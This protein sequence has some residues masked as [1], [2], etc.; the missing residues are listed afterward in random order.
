MLLTVIDPLA[1]AVMFVLLFLVV[2]SVLSC[3]LILIIYLAN[4]EARA[5]GVTYGLMFTHVF[6]IGLFAL[7]YW[8]C[9]ELPFPD[10]FKEMILYV[11]PVLLVIA[12]IVAWKP[13]LPGTQKKQEA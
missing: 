7:V 9:I 4:T 1:G 8:L 10:P 11:Y 5:V 12:A 2:H 3:I 13:G 6:F